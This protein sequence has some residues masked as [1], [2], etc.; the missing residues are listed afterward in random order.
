MGLTKAHLLT[1]K[2]LYRRKIRWFNSIQF[3]GPKKSTRQQ[4]VHVGLRLLIGCPQILR[5]QT[6]EDS[7][8]GS[9]AGL[10][11]AIGL[12][13]LQPKN[14]SFS[15]NLINDDGY[16]GTGLNSFFSSTE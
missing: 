5:R 1:I 4:C 2:P 8:L 6:P 13:A 11:G 7:S 9:V 10:L 16:W 12:L 15:P 3:I 14:T